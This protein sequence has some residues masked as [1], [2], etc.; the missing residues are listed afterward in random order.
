MKMP[1][2]PSSELWNFVFPAPVSKDFLS[3]PE[4]LETPT[5]STLPG[6]QTEK[7]SLGS[8]VRAESPKDLA[9]EF[10]ATSRG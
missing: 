2:V 5:S 7:T 9:P 6:S 1:P 10:R 8:R 4:P 3:G